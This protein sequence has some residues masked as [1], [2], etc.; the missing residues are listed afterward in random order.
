MLACL[1]LSACGGGGSGGS[2][3]ATSVV[4]PVTV[5]P[6]PAPT[7]TPTPTPTPA[8]TPSTTTLAP[9]AGTWYGPCLGRTQD[10]A[11]LSAAASGANALQLNL[12]R[13]FHATD[14][15]AGAVAASESLSADFSLTY[16]STT[17][18]G[19]VLTPGTSAIQVPLDLVTIAIPAY[20]RTRSG[21]ALTSTSANGVRT[22]CIDYPDGP[23]CSTDA[24]LQPA[25]SA[26]G[27]LY[28]DNG[29]LVLLSPAGASYIADIRYTKVRATTPQ[30][31]GPV[32]Q[33]IDTVQGSGTLASSGRT[34]TVNY[35][36]WL[37]DA[38][39]ADFKGA[40]FDTSIGRTPFTFRLGTGQVIAGWDQGLL[41]MQ[42]GGKRT[43]IIPASLA[44]GRAGSGTTIPPDAPLI[45]E[46][47]LISVQ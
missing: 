8:P 12:V 45:F 18:A 4:P 41:G 21:P 43:L 5:T 11:I 39:K 36:G 23:V 38:T 30:S 19:A 24:G 44:Y 34:L 6:T 2:A 35:T 46:V 17:T 29:E 31:Q 40:Q 32:F 33:R 9:Y 10:T 16:I 7:P 42:A 37:Y 3:G 14:G 47:D 27:A 28:I 25:T 20:S 22:W 13:N 26:P 1:S 15:C